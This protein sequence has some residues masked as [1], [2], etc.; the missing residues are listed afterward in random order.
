MPEEGKRSYF[1]D[2][3]NKIILKII[4]KSQKKRKEFIIHVKSWNWKSKQ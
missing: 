1:L 4:R 2:H 3:Y